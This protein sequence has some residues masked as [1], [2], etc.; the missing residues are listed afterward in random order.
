MAE[1]KERSES[2]GEAFPKQQA[3]LRT[4][5]GYGREIGPAG[6]FYCAVIEDIL[7]RADKAVMGQD[8]PAMIAIYRE[9][10]ETAE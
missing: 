2:L 10:E 8:L 9:M 4:L 7:R 3:R 1:T 6:A 5:L